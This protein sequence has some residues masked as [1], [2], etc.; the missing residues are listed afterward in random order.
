MDAAVAQFVHFEG[1]TLDLGRRRLLVGQS[2]VDLR[3]KSFDVLSYLAEQHGRLA[4]KD[5]IIGAI[6]PNVIAT[7]DS[8]ARC[9]SDI[10]QALGEAGRDVIKTVPGRG[11][12]FT[13]PVTLAAGDQTSPQT[14]TP[15]PPEPNRPSWNSRR[16]IAGSMMLAVIVLAI[17]IWGLQRIWSK[18]SEST[19]PDRPSIAVLPFKNMSGDAGQDYI[20]DGLCMANS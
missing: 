3:P 16:A 15:I 10:R 2:P 20:S 17:A 5:E 13:A 11:Y 1:F 19:L 14:S 4:T 7:D 8:L 12:V 18:P 9:V 6:W